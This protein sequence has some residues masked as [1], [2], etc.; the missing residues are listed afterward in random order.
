MRRCGL[1]W[2]GLRCGLRESEED[3]GRPPLPPPF[4]SKIFSGKDLDSN[5]DTVLIRIDSVQVEW[6]AAVW[7]GWTGGGCF[8]H[9]CGSDRVAKK[10]KAGA[11]TPAFSVSIIYLLI[12]DSRLSR[13]PMPLIFLCGKPGKLLL[14]NGL[15]VENISWRRR[16]GLTAALRAVLDALPARALRA[17]LDALPA[18]ALRAVLDALPRVKDASCGRLLRF[19]PTL[20]VI[21]RPCAGE[22][23]RAGGG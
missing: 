1:R 3:W 22:R 4:D 6:V 21:Q 23:L 18:R 2:L 14:G 7:T 8:G 5:R 11:E 19:A 15:R 20:A 9:G 10:E 16:K 17:V 13:I 12:K